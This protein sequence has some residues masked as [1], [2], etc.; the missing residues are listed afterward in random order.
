MIR[1]GR[2]AEGVALLDEAMVAVAAGELLR[3]SQVA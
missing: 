2:T 1:S 3:S